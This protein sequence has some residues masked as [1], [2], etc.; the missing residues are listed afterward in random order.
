MT[1]PTSSIFGGDDLLKR[2]EEEQAEARHLN[3]LPSED[4]LVEKVT[5][6]VPLKV[7][8]CDIDN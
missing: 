1:L 4:E 6:K 2:N 8:H 7:D 3:S 5:G